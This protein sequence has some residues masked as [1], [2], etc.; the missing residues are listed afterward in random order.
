MLCPDVAG[1]RPDDDAAQGRF[2][3]AR[4]AHQ[5]ERLAGLDV[6]AHIVDRLVDLARRRKAPAR[7]AAH[8]EVLAQGGDAN[9]R[10]GVRRHAGRHVARHWAAAAVSPM[11]TQ[12]R[13]GWAALV[14]VRAAVPLRCNAAPPSGQRG[15]NLQP[16]ERRRGIGRLSLDGGQ[17][18]DGAIDARH[19]LQQGPGVRD[20]A[21][22][23]GR[24]PSVHLPRRARHTS[25]SAVGRGSPTTAMLW[26]INRMAVPDC[27]L[28][29]RISSQDLVLH[30]DVERRGRL[31]GDQQR[32]PVGHRH[33]RERPLAH[34]AGEFMRIGARP[35][36]RI[37]N[38][39]RAPAGAA[40]RSPKL[41]R[42]VRSWMAIASAI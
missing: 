30:G 2:S 18:A 17:A 28:R 13:T 35:R 12:Q 37:G 10:I 23:T 11:G 32:R 20:A 38:A 39:D 21:A 9:Q 8:G 26:V 42:P 27:S 7:P 41:A 25:R 5:P 33:C 19:R 16:L 1:I 31:V 34:A 29:S 4:F 40:T 22:P 14:C 36:L 3:R 24:R 6:E 15:W